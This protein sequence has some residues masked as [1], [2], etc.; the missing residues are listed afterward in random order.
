MTQLRVSAPQ[1]IDPGS[2]SSSEGFSPESTLHAES[3]SNSTHRSRNSQHD[4]EATITVNTTSQMAKYWNE[5]DDGSEAGGLDDEY[6]IYIDPAENES[7]P[8][9]DTVRAV[10]AVPFEKAKQ[11]FR[12]DTNKYY[13]H[14]EPDLEAARAA[15]E[16]R[17][18][19]GSRDST[20]NYASTAVNTDSEEEGYM[21]S[22]LLPSR[23]YQTLYALPSVGEQKRMRYRENVLFWSMIACFIGSFL[24]LGISGAL[25]AMGR[26]KL[27]IEVDAAVTLGVVFSL[28]SACSGL[29]MTMYRRDQ[30]TMSLSL[31]VYSTFGTL[32][33]LNSLLLILV[34]G[35][36]P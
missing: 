13:P 31:M 17:H 1:L 29:G 25:L 32:C 27:R 7:F 3:H 4:S 30:P 14:D 21:S 16:Q 19:L 2:P 12:R 26:H 28:F 10:F 24:L 15:D 18:L 11:W 34:V 20:F 22:D 35:N 5:Y 23:G 33:I 6:A 36:A 8:G 9:M